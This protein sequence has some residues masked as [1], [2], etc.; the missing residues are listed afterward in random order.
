LNY[1]YDPNGNPTSVNNGQESYTYDDLNRLTSGVGPFGTLNYTYDQ[2]GNRL[3]AVVN[4]TRTSYAYNSYNN[5]LQTAGSTSYSYDPNGNMVSK[6]SGSTSWTYKY[7]YENRLKQVILPGTGT[8]LQATYDGDGRRIQTVAGDTTVFAYLP[9]SWDPAYVKDVTTG[10]VTDIIS[11]GGLRVA[12]V[13]GAATSYYHLD[14]LGSVRL[15]T[16]QSS[17]LS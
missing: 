9:S 17:S 7:D 13:Q 11:A 2:I 12:K 15:V 16:Q 10:V 3:S 6:T 14:R 5:E 4:N 1:A 8:V